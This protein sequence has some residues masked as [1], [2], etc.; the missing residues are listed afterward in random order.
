MRRRHALIAGLVVPFSKLAFAEGALPIDAQARW[1]AGLGP[2]AG[3]APSAEWKTYAEAENERWKQAESRRKAMTDWASREVL[4]LL[5]T[6]HTLFY[7]FAGPDALH[8]LALFGGARRT[9]L[10]GLEPVGVLPDPARV[11][12]GY[13]ARLGAAMSDVFRLTFFRTKE[14]STDFERDGVLAALVVT[15]VRF[16][17]KVMSVQ[18]WTRVGEADRWGWVGSPHWLG[19]SPKT[20]SAPDAAR[21][22]WVHPSGQARR[23]DYSRMDLAN[24]ALM[25]QA[26]FLANV[27]SLAP[28][29]TFVKAA[30]YLLAETRFSR[31]RQ[32]ILDDSAVVLQDDTGVPLRHFDQ[33]W[34]LRLFGR[35]EPPVTPFEER[36]QPDLRSAFERRSAS[37]LPFGIG[38]HVRPDRSNLMIASKGQ[39]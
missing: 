38:Y 21:I 7:P 28:V 25:N 32:M 10:V 34:A 8:A 12:S 15:I 14:M 35:Y 13:F 18:T 31:L 22:E 36:A 30:M 23:L 1:L 4:P 17:G 6:D 26:P 2:L 16:G 33:R 24:A 37:P 5:P 39:G 27:H 11:P 9:M 3:E 29:I 20:S 19:Q